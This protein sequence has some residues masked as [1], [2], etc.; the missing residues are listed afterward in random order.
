MPSRSLGVVQESEVEFG[1]LARE[2]IVAY[3]ETGEPMFAAFL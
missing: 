3:V 1:E 2:A